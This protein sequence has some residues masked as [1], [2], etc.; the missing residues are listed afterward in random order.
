MTH[1][2]TFEALNVLQQLDKA[3]TTLQLHMDSGIITLLLHCYYSSGT[4]FCVARE[5][6]DALLNC[7]QCPSPC[8]HV[9][10]FSSLAFTQEGKNLGSDCVY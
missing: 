1:T 9:F 2:F 8:R 3:F 7:P 10:P 4:L 5:K 6:H